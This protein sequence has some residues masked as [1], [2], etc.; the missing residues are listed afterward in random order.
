MKFYDN[1]KSVGKK[2]MESFFN[3]ADKLK[4]EIFKGSKTAAV[5]LMQL[6][7]NIA[8]IQVKA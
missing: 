8:R 2:E 7:N 4:E 5:E 6:E 1:G 3:Y